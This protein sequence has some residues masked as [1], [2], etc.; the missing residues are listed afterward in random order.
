MN[1]TEDEAKEI[2]VSNSSIS[3]NHLRYKFIE[4][5]KNPRKRVILVTWSSIKSCKNIAPSGRNNISTTPILHQYYASIKHSWNPL[6]RPQ[7]NV[8]RF[9]FY[10]FVN[11][12]IGKSI[13]WWFWRICVAACDRRCI[14]QNS[15]LWTTIK[16]EYPWLYR[17]WLWRQW[18]CCVQQWI[19]C[20]TW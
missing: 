14:F 18:T 11:K 8:A 1:L 20:G 2:I 7:I 9:H 12:T 3:D 19:C 15:F 13:I 6:P 17:I 5:W 4:N 10:L 16:S